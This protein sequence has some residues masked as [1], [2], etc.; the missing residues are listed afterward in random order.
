MR[1]LVER[2][3]EREKERERERER[4]EGV[5]NVGVRYT[6]F[7]MLY[8]EDHFILKSV[9]EGLLFLDFLVPF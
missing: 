7:G 8:N 4:E 6:E 2:E 1:W 3:R 5:I 9:E